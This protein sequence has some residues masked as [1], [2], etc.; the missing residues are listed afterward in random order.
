[1]ANT[2]LSTYS[3]GGRAK[4]CS[5]GILGEGG[6]LKPRMLRGCGSSGTEKDNR[7]EEAC[8]LGNVGKLSLSA[9]ARRDHDPNSLWAICGIDGIG[10]GSDLRWESK[11]N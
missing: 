5:G 7:F 9:T 10:G 4:S 2:C 1:M 3:H 11:T 6:P 8:A